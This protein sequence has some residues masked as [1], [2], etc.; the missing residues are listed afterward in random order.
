MTRSLWE[1]D[2]DMSMMSMPSGISISED[3]THVYVDVAVPGVD[4]KDVDITFD[5]GMLWVK[6]E[7]KEEEKK[8][9][10]YRKATSSFSY[11]VAVPGEIDSNQ[12][13]EAKPWHGMMRVSF[14]KSK[15]SQP[16]KITVKAE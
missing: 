9:K 10:Y 7:V 6:G 3:D 4:P 16:K 8:K 12:D 13:P 1:D 14:V 5:K 15:A 11:R 2:D